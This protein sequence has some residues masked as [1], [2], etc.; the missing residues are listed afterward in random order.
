MRTDDGSK[1]AR[2]GITPPSLNRSARQGRSTE[3][4]KLLE[5]PKIGKPEDAAFLRTDPWRVLRIISEFVEGFEALAGTYPAVTLFGS[6]RTKPQSMSYKA[7]VEVARLLGEA[8]FTIVT[9][10]GPGIMEAGNRGAKLAGA[11]SIGLNI[12]LPFEQAVNHFVDVTVEFRHF[13]VR[14]TMMVKYSQA[15]VI[16]PGGYGTMDEMLESLTLIQTGKIHN[17][18]VILFGTRYWKGLLDWMRSTV[19]RNGMIGPHDLD[20]MI[21]TD[22]PEEIRD[23]IVRSLENGKERAEKEEGARQSTREKY[24]SPV[25]GGGGGA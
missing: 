8:G 21:L 24:Q 20:L 2:R 18:P 23:H 14:K 13:F 9:G 12:E 15:F 22:S 6:A 3:D 11:R 25:A 17:F 5:A 16:F 4:E 1:R 10:G 7:A 19:Q